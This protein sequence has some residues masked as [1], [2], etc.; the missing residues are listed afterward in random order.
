MSPRPVLIA[1]P[2]GDPFVSE[3]VEDLR[4]EGKEVLIGRDAESVLRMASTR[5]PALIVLDTVVPGGDGFSLCRQLK[6][7]PITADIPVYYFS[8]VMARDRCVEAGA[9][10]F[11]LKPTEQGELLN[12]I[13]EVL[14]SR[15][16][17]LRRRAR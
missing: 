14:S 8:V 10:G 17:Q 5:Q 3:L 6:A 2:D 4:A 7:D 12:R 13:R 9:D 15:V 16:T 1:A 11:M